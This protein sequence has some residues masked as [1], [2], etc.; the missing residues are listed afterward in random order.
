MEKDVYWKWLKKQAIY[1]PHSFMHEMAYW[2][3]IRWRGTIVWN[4]LALFWSLQ[5][6]FKQ[7]ILLALKGCQTDRNTL[8]LSCEYKENY[9]NKPF[10]ANFPLLSSLFLPSRSTPPYFSHLMDFRNVLT[11]S[12]QGKEENTLESRDLIHGYQTWSFMPKSSLG[13]QDL[14]YLYFRERWKLGVILH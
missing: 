12:N 9:L 7:L 2:F 4:S 13:S 3:K 10:G 1:Q 11:T 5:L 8:F 6:V 14:Y